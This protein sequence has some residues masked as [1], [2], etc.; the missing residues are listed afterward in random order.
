MIR[1]LLKFLDGLPFRNKKPKEWLNVST[2]TATGQKPPPNNVDLKS[3]HRLLQ[4]I[5][6][7]SHILFDYYHIIIRIEEQ[8][9]LMCT[10]REFVKLNT[11][12]SSRTKN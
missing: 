3:L 12:N 6:Q 8:K 10:Y 5:S 9:S 2:M 4:L 11:S 7:T 1:Q